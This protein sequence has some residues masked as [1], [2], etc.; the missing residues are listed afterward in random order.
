MPLMLYITPFY[1]LIQWVKLYGAT[2]AAGSQNASALAALTA[3]CFVT[4]GSAFLTNSHPKEDL[5]R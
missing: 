4:A 1:N 5:K 3:Y 2:I